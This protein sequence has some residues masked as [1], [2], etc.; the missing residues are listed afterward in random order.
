MM[1]WMTYTYASISVVLVAA[2]LALRNVGVEETDRPQIPLWSQVLL[3]GLFWPLLL[4]G[5]LGYVL[6]QHVRPSAQ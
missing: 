6:Y 5:I 3:V 1:G 4:G 2:H